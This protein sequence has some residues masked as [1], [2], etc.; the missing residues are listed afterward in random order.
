MRY[1]CSAVAVAAYGSGSASMRAL[2]ALYCFFCFI[3]VAMS[4]VFLSELLQS[5][6]QEAPRRPELVEVRPALGVL[7]EPLVAE[8]RRDLVPV[9]R[10]SGQDREHDPLERPLEHLGHLLAHGTPP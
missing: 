6:R 8:P 1:R 9:R 3:H 4:A 10:A 2:A 7:G 5:F